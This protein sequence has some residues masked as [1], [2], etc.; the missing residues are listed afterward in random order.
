MS[1]F[2]MKAVIKAV[3]KVS[4]PIRKIIN[5]VSPIGRQFQ[6]I[7]RNAADV[8]RRFSAILGPLAIIGS[9]ASIAGITALT[10][11]IAAIGNTTGDLADQVNFSRQSLQEWEYIAKFTGASAE[12]LDAG[13][14]TMNKSMAQLRAN[15]G[16]LVSAIG[17][18]SP[19]LLKQLKAC[20]DNEEAFDL[21][22]A[23]IRKVEDPLKKAYLA[24]T[25]FGSASGPALIGMA[26]TSKEALAE[27]RKEA[28]KTGNVMDNQAIAASQEY[29]NN[30]D[31]LRA[32]ILGVSK[33]LVGKLLPIVNPLIARMTAWIAANRQLIN[34]RLDDFFRRMA[35]IVQR[36]DFEGIIRSIGRFASGV[37]SAVKFIGGWEN[38]VWALIA[39][40]NAGLISSILKLSGSI[41]G[42]LKFAPAVIGFLINT[43]GLLAGG[44]LK[45][46]FLATRAILGFNF[47]LLANP[48]GLV[49]GGI[50]ILAAAGI[51]LYKKWEPFRNF[52]DKLWKGITKAFTNGFQTIKP[53]IDMMMKIIN[54]VAAVI[55]KIVGGAQKI[56]KWIGSKWDKE[57]DIQS[58][59]APQVAPSPYQSKPAISA[60]PVLSEQF[61]PIPSQPKSAYSGLS[62]KITPA[63]AQ[64]KSK[65][66]VVV[67]FDNMPPSA[68]ISTADA[69]KGLDLGVETGHALPAGVR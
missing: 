9:T 49:V 60:Y 24:T 47:A 13:L 59:P 10:K 44:F 57:N 18:V 6:S 5:N 58:V 14:Q 39:V 68:Y 37:N 16:P 55:D 34:Q 43:T 35:E 29:T 20:K 52:I 62:D 7:G 26:N 27:L 40:M 33:S 45:G 51:T 8:G 30:M 54:P 67:R 21:M 15:S 69:D 65:A 12:Q 53:I 46:V 42:L 22:I 11:N 64:Q 66:E 28:I 1:D 48:I 56:G 23:S 32:S 38:A 17:K 41:V 25:F 36:I 61:T 3:D 19:A 63:P 50:A 4:G 31:K 2:E